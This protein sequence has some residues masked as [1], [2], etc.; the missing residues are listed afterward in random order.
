MLSTIS[1]QLNVVKAAFT[2]SRRAAG[3][4]YGR[5]PTIIVASDADAQHASTPRSAASGGA[6]LNAAS[7]QT[8]GSV[9]TTRT[10]NQPVL[11]L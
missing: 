1:S 4:G 6:A 7:G 8:C 9:L 10:S 11:R 2:A 3:S 5:P